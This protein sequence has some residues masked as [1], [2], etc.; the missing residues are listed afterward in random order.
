MGPWPHGAEWLVQPGCLWGPLEGE[1]AALPPR[2]RMQARALG[3]LVC[4]G[5]MQLHAQWGGGGLRVARGH[6]GAAGLGEN[7]PPSSLFVTLTVP[8]PPCQSGIGAGDPLLPHPYQGPTEPVPL[9]PAL[10]SREE[11]CALGRG[12]WGAGPAPYLVFLFVPS[13]LEP[14]CPWDPALPTGVTVVLGFSS[15]ITGGFGDTGA[16][17][18]GL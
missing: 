14:F 2:N 11:V 3:S 16:L 17:E 5:F 6:G 18:P 10:G 15:S 8:G 13:T 9:C 12:L 7:T 1:T 4:V